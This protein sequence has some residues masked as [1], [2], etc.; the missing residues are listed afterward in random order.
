MADTLALPRRPSDDLALL[1]QQLL[2][3]L[4][5]LFEQGSAAEEPELYRAYLRHAQALAW[6]GVARRRPG[7]PREVLDHLQSVQ[8]FIDAHLP[9]PA[10]A[11]EEAA[12]ALFFALDSLYLAD[13]A[14]D[15][16]KAETRLA[17][18]ERSLTE[19]EV[20][21]VLWA[22]RDRYLRRGEVQRML[23][24]LRRPTSARVGQILAGL[25]HENLVVRMPGR[26]Q[27]NP[28][29]SFY[30]LSPLGF[31]A[32]Q[33]L[34]LVRN[35]SP[36]FR[37]EEE[38]WAAYLT[39]ERITAKDK[40]AEPGR[41]TVLWSY[42][43]GSGSTA[44]LAHA[45]PLAAGRMAASDA[46]RLL[47]LDLDVESPGLDAHLAPEGLGGCR[48]LRGLIVDFYK[49]PPG[50][51]A[52][53][54]REA[55]VKREYVLQ[56]K[57]EEQ[58]NFFYLPSGFGP[59]SS[60]GSD[61]ERAEALARLQSEAGTRLGEAEDE[62]AETGPAFLSELRGALREDL[63]AR[64]LAEPH[65]GLGL[66]AWAA[67][68]ELADELVL[69]APLSER[70]PRSLRAMIGNFLRRRAEESRE[71]VSR[72]GF[73]FTS[74]R[75]GEEGNLD[76]WIEREVFK[77]E[78]SKNAE[79]HFR[80]VVLSEGER[81]DWI[82]LLAGGLRNPRRRTDER[83]LLRY[84]IDSAV[85]PHRSKL[86]RSIAAGALAHSRPESRELVFKMLFEEGV[87]NQDPGIQ[88]PIQAA[89]YTMLGTSEFHHRSQSSPQ[90]FRPDRAKGRMVAD[91]L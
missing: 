85:D 6:Q 16:A 9:A 11:C 82:G 10:G 53:W 65:A 79:H 76:A 45:A 73:L 42:R 91:P 26:A 90:R 72:V 21:R 12:F 2:Q 25:D 1:E 4:N 88:I 77:V 29:A 23:N 59:D 41:V 34:S 89:L 84:Y 44:A 75:L 70:D 3:A 66:T 39:P 37:L 33:R 43:G 19:R 49:V 24:L 55:L 64:T 63:Y 68:L 54:L 18:R 5:R 67:V 32:C 51:R 83:L 15:E 86:D 60:A 87:R 57:P 69:C 80:A 81:I 27:G 31:E 47:V 14:M 28:E 56:P 7:T 71:T 40:A 48:G 50:E 8:P 30:S 46:G 78:L 74:A 61:E 62:A 17:D 13:G 36:Y 20:L 22:H 58:P 52:K 38:T 35:R